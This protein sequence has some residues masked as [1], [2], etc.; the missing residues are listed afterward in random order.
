MSKM[1]KEDR[2]A[3]MDKLFVT[4]IIIFFLQSTAWAEEWREFYSNARALGMGNASLAVTN[5]ETALLLNPAALGRLRDQYGTLFDP[6]YETNTNAVNVYKI[7]G[8]GNNFTVQKAKDT[9]DTYR[10]TY[11]HHRAQ[12]FPSYVRKYFGLGFLYR[13][14]LDAQ[15]NTAGDTLNVNYRNDIALIGGLSLRLFD[16]RIKLGVNGKIISRIEVQNAAVNPAGDLDMTTIGATEGMGLSTD[17]GLLLTGPWIWLPTL[18]AV[19][20]DV[21][22]TTFDKRSGVRGT[23]ASTP[24]KTEQ[25][26]DVAMALFPIHSNSWRS[27]WTLEYKDVTMARSDRDSAK[28]M[29]FGFEYNWADIFFL[30]GGYNQRYWTAGLELASE[31]IQ[32]Q[33]ASYGEEIG[34][35]SAPQED[36]RY[37]VKFAF[38]F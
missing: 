32:W 29:H 17:A 13:T 10:D 3:S 26:I 22:G 31:F 28:R 36:R 9:T 8:I 20:R 34:T 30:R 25:Q 27:A 37:V 1:I 19:I 15:M 14:H 35:E 33:V 23:F 18:G 5:D 4:T 21:G 2:I 38:R 11:Y 24:N 7:A 12:V 16:G 6:E